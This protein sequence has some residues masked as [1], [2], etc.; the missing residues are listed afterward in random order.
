MMNGK[1]QSVL[2]LSGP[3][4][5]Q[6]YDCGIPPYNRVFVAGA[7][8]CCFEVKIVPIHKKIPAAYV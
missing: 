6:W 3:D 2:T 8:L 1:L 4:S 5:S 7:H